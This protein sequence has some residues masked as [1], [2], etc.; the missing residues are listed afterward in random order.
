M[1]LDSTAPKFTE[2]H[3]DKTYFKEHN[4]SI[5]L[6]SQ[7]LPHHS[8]E[9][10]NSVDSQFHVDDT[11]TMWTRWSSSTTVNYWLVCVRW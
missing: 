4:L 5:I 11:R 6:H 7:I 1:G 8:L 10:C 2:Y 3:L 9:Y